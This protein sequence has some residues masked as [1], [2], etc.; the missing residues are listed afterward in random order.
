LV[1][2]QKG[3]AVD[4]LEAAKN[5]MP[6]ATL[7]ILFLP[8]NLRPV[9][10]RGEGSRLFDTSG[11]SYIDYMLSSGPLIVGH[12]HPEVV[13]AVQRQAALGS[14]FYM[15]NEPAIRLASKIVGAVPC[16]ESLRFQLGGS[17]ATANAIRLA[18]GHTGRSLIIK[19]EGGFHGWHDTAQHAIAHRRDAGV[20]AAAESAGIPTAIG[21]DIRV[22]R[23]NDIDSV[24]QIVAD[25]PGEV[26]A[27]IVEPMQ[28]VLLPREGFL[29]GLREI[30]TADGIVLIFDEIVTGFRLAWGGGQEVFGVVPDLA[31][32]G[33]AIG[34]GYPISAVV[35]RADLLEQADPR[36]KGGGSYCYMGGTLTGNPIAA[37][38]GLA[39]LDIL[40]RPGSYPRLYALAA[41]LRDGLERVGRTQGLPLKTLGKGPIIQ[42]AFTE[43]DAFETVEDLSC[44][45]AGLYKRFAYE[46][47]S[48][49]VMLLP[50]GKIYVSLAHSEADIDE[51][52][53]I[54]EA[55][56][57][58]LTAAAKPAPARRGA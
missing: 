34:G 7:G 10:Q 30:A 31:C 16:G 18:R 54:A 57:R 51:T 26:A 19:F 44:A 21:Q 58:S 13:A 45:D 42:V 33:K 50:A 23:Y 37:A 22:A 14:S 52:V 15:L 17:D 32:F 35:G 28:R 24:R 47:I 6:G 27:I 11:K 56:L 53:A 40:E 43:R 36:R 20:Q 3:L 25:H 2:G 49:G 29:A 48:R 46:M 1:E 55:A 4:L 12:A 5:V 8:E 39:T 9:I 41:R 38:A